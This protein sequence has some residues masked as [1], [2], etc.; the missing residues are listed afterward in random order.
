MH[1][2][3]VHPDIVEDLTRSVYRLYEEA[4]CTD[5]KDLSR[6]L[7]EL[8]R[9]I[10]R[11]GGQDVTD[12]R[13]REFFVRPINIWDVRRGL[14]D[15]VAHLAQGKETQI[16]L[17]HYGALN[18]VADTL[19][20]FFSAMGQ[21]IPHTCTREHLLARLHSLRTQIH[22]NGGECSFRIRWKDP[23][24][25]DHIAIVNIGRQDNAL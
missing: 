5:Y 25:H 23:E 3:N 24:G 20:K 10:C 18:S 14:D 7:R 22:V 17:G 16:V 19:E 12:G 4:G 6:V 1:I 13:A 9:N 11:K 15:P 8:A 2:S 21:D